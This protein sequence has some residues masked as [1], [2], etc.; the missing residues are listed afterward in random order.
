MRRTW[1]NCWSRW[2]WPSLPGHWK[3]TRELSSGP[4]IIHLKLAQ[5]HVP[6]GADGRQAEAGELRQNHSDVVGAA[7][8]VGGLDERRAL[9]RQR[10]GASGDVEHVRRLHLI[11]KPVAA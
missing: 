6:R 10:A 1:R 5:F 8:R 3:Q 7:A 9:V 4:G 2:I 11:V